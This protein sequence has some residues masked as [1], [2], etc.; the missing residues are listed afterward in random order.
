[1]FHASGSDR[2]I[3]VATHLDVLY[4]G[5][6]AVLAPQWRAT[7]YRERADLRSGMVL[8]AD[9]DDNGRRPVVSPDELDAFQR[10][11][12]HVVVWTHDGDAWTR[13]RG[14][15]RA[16]LAKNAPE[17]VVVATLTGTRSG[18]PLELTSREAE[19]LQSFL[20]GC[21]YGEVAQRLGVS[22]STVKTHAHR[23]YQRLG[24]SSR[25]QAVTWA[26]QNGWTPFPGSVEAEARPER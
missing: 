25:M 26:I 18:R 17:E 11:G 22:R 13:G 6:S 5:I 14:R 19:V 3:A 16:V 12:V 9:V 7:R 24:V 1:M 20:D 2:S 4:H 10:D 23:L 8:L 21:S 15:P